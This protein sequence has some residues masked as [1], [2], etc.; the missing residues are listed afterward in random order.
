MPQLFTPLALRG[1]T[2]KNRIVVAPMCQYA[3]EGGFV[4][5]WHYQHHC[6]FAI[7]GA[8]LA[9]VEATA[10][11]PAGRITRGCSGLW[12]DGQIAGLARIATM[13][14][15]HGCAAGIQIG[16]AGRRASCAL[17]WDGGAPLGG[18]PDDG[19]WPTVGPSPLAERD[20]GPVPHEL[21]P[22]EIAA[23]VTAFADAARRALE[24]G[25]DTIEI[26]GAHGYLLHSFISPI[27]NRRSDDFGG[28][29]ANRMRFALLVSHAVRA[30]WP[31]DQPVFY[32]C[33]AVDTI[34][35]GLTLDDTIALAR[36]LKQI[37]IDVIDCSSGGINGPATLAQH[38]VGFGY[39]VPYAEAIRNQARIKTMAVGLITEPALAEQILAQ[40]Q[41]DLIALARE[42]LADPNW[43]YRAA[44]QLGLDNPHGV[45]PRNY[46]LTLA[47]R[48]A[49]LADS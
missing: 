28:S 5:D 39:Q 1:L 16:H 23:H 29:L 36:A 9:F 7:G 41:A 35:G 37:G 47:R 6:R 22:T 4:T 19:A 49:I 48:A 34:D 2:L 18:G 11:T 30:L 32:R 27:A 12:E 17:P 33:S 8:G 21:S 24:A 44:L 45:L 20:N 26:H 42:L 15:S 46:A 43:P 3:A 38:K 10:V 25:F 13:Y 40:G 14:K 31:A